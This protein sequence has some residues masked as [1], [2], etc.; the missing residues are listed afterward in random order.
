MNLT[1]VNHWNESYHGGSLVVND[2]AIDYKLLSEVADK[3]II[4]NPNDKKLSSVI[5]IGCCPG[6]FLAYF[7]TKGLILNGLDFIDNVNNLKSQL[8]E[9]GFRADEFWMADFEKFSTQKKFSIVCS[10]GFIEHFVNFDKM[11][12]KHADMVEPGGFIFVST[13]NFR[14]GLQYLFHTLTDLTNRTKHHLPSMSIN[15]WRSILIKNGFEISYMGYVGNYYWDENS[16][17]VRLQFWIQRGI[18]ILSSLYE[19]VFGIDKNIGSHCVI[20]AKKV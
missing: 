8:I 20:V 7:G 14:S 18:R 9:N 16:S 12:T 1:D 15:K 3:Y 4:S 5:E 11:L 17:K 10:F 19:S 13:P 2:D 6:R